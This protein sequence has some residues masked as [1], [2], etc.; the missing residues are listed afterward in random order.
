MMNKRNA[1]QMAERIIRENKNP[2]WGNLAAMATHDE[3]VECI[4]AL[5]DALKKAERKKLS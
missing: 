3:M 2:G 5:L 1:M 4:A